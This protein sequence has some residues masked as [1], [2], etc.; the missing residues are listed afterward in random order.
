MRKEIK[1]LVQCKLTI[2][3]ELSIKSNLD[4]KKDQDS[5][6]VFAF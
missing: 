1:P 6:L 2:F 4:L 5:L 3:P